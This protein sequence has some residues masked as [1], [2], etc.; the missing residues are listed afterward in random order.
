MTG[1]LDCMEKERKEER[2]AESDNVKFCIFVFHGARQ[3]DQHQS[4]QI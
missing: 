4:N 3:A 1:G 2:N